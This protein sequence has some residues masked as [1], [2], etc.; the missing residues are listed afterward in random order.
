MEVGMNKGRS[1]T[2][3]PQAYRVINDIENDKCQTIPAEPLPELL[4]ACRHRGLTCAHCSRYDDLGFQWHHTII[5]KN[6]VFC[7]S[8]YC[9]PCFKLGT[10]PSPY[11]YNS[12]EL[13]SSIEE[14]FAKKRKV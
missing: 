8:W 13:P 1:K 5:I 2:P 7:H 3:F 11:S 10:L 14:P 4:D 9:P 12:T 6:G